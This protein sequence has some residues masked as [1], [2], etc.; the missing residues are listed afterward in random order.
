MKAALFLVVVTAAF[1]PALADDITFTNRTATFTT[2]QGQP[3]RRVQL[4]RADLDG[5]IWRDGASGGRI[6][7]TN[8]A[9]DLLE[10]LGISSN[11]IEVARARAQKKA[12]ADARY[13]SQV[14]VES[15][16]K[17]QAQG[18]WTN[19]TA[20]TASSDTPSLGYAGNSPAPASAPDSMNPVF[21]FDPFVPIGPPAPS[22]PSAATA[23]GAG[24]ALDSAGAPAAALVPM[25][26]SAANPAPALSAGP[27]R[28][29]PSAPPSFSPP[30]RPGRRH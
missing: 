8:L 20:P 10:S 15:R 16:S 19:A 18:G 2:L 23:P 24:S 12:I 22:A 27:A 17:A 25:A 5:L 4:V 6:C 7:Y 3:Y 30:P 1:Q 14:I 11:R 26:A 28:S 21:L 9:P 13:H 29:A